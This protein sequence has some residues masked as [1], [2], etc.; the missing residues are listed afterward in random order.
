[1]ALNSQVHIYSV[2]SKAF[3]TAEEMALDKEL[4]PL[5]ARRT[6]I[7]KSKKKENT[8]E[9]KTEL[10]EINK[11]ISKLKET[12]KD[13][14]EKNTEIRIL[15]KTSL[16]DKNVVSL[17]ES[18]LTKACEM[19]A[20]NLYEDLFIVRT[21][22]YGI[23]DDIINMG[24]IHNEEKYVLFSASAGQIRTKKSVFIRESLWKQIENTITCGLSIDKINSKGGINTNKYLAYLALASSATDT[25]EGFDIDKT[26]VVD[27]FSTSF[28]TCVDYINR[29]TFEIE[30]NKTMAITID[31]M[32]GCGIMLPKVSRKAFMCRLPFVKG[33]LVPFQYNS[34]IKQNG[35][36]SKIK[37]IYG[38]EYDIFEDDIQII[39][40]KSQFKMY[41]YYE[42]WEEYKENFKKFNCNAGICNVEED[43]IKDARL[44]Y[45][46]LQ[47]LSDLSD[48]ELMYLASG[49]NEDIEKISSD[50]KTML[51]ILGVTDYNTNK[52]YTQQ[53]LELYPEMLQEEHFRK[54][55]RDLK[56]KLVND[57]RC[58]KF[59]VNGKYT[60][61]IPDLYA[62]CEWLFLGQENPQGILKN[63]EVSCKLY[64]EGV[65]LDVL[66]SPHLF[67]EHC[68]RNNNRSEMQKR[69]FISNG[70]YTSVHD[71]IT[72]ILQNDVDGD[73]GLVISDDR[74][75]EMAERNIE[76]W[77]VVPLYYEMAKAKDKPLDN[78]AMYNGMVNA[79]SGGNI[80]EV[81][82][83]ISKCWNSDEV[84]QDTVDVI[85]FLCMLNNF[86]IDYAKTLFTVTPPKE[87]KEKIRSYTGNKLPH[88]FKYAKDKTDDQ[89]MTPNNSTVNKLNW[90]IKD[91]RFNFKSAQLGKFDY[92]V[93]LRNKDVVLDQNIV[94]RYE[95]EK[96]KVSSYKFEDG[97]EGNHNYIWE[98]VKRNICDGYDIS[99]VVDNLVIYLFREGSRTKVMFWDCFADIVLENI[100]DNI[101][102][103]LDNGWI[104][105]E[106]CGERIYSTT[107][108]IKYC[109]RCSK[110]VRKKQNRENMRVKRQYISNY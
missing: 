2:D 9:V 74:L 7:K 46:M 60:Y 31:H 22:Y 110:T 97:Y 101:E 45:Q 70:V 102:K 40:T 84:T 73:K 82:N 23:L 44:N 56:K 25:W 83:N 100:K 28:E 87:V 99:Y 20:G 63:G 1:M 41:K 36:N 51:K 15:R 8:D 50:R 38:K 108:N 93:L 91:Q 21:F 16:N 76:K 49:Q 103:P 57:G 64:Q 29:D 34:F 33:L 4:E 75:I 106:E 24:F 53:C 37:D 62:F 47:T 105:C 14:I 98:N 30:K 104:M 77:N 86:V 69:W 67:L 80:G 88:F 107:S 65:K 78:K 17:F 18:S 3:Y 32:D 13:L 90:I 109:E 42:N 43:F 72:R 89:I 10:K 55:L 52:N 68:I 12:L 58:A 11:E 6:E 81:S 35:G 71:P 85:K 66:R 94:D 39:F 61:L 5:Y 19:K 96:K 26:I 54:I 92:N 79:Y 27:D 59:R 48:E 95:A